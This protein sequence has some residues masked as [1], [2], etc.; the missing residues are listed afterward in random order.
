M[1]ANTLAVN[2][3]KAARVRPKIAGIES[4]AKTRSVVPSATITMSIGVTCH[5]P[6]RRVVSRAPSYRVVTGSTDCVQRI[7]R[8][9]AGALV[10]VPGRINR[11]AV[12]TRKI[13]NR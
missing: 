3:R 9:S 7:S 4:R 12:Y 1:R 2:T 8:L 10:A 5:R 13:P 11:T 6:A